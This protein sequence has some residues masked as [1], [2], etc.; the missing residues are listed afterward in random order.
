M[1]PYS[2]ARTV[3]RAFMRVALLISVLTFVVIGGMV[4][5]DQWIGGYVSALVSFGTACVIAAIC[6]AIF[7]L[8]N[9]TGL[10]ISIAFRD[11]PPR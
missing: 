3:R 8:V 10:A 9:A 7:A 4:L 1:P 2:P 5:L 6:I 11:E